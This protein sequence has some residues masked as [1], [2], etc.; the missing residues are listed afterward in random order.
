MDEEKQLKSA[1]DWQYKPRHTESLLGNEISSYLKKRHRTFVKNA[2]IIDTWETFI[3]FAMRPFCQLEKCVGNT[4][5]L[6]VQP[7]PYMHQAQMLSDELLEKINQRAP[8]CGIRKIKI[9]PMKKNN[10]E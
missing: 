10:T 7:G 8:R 6:Q 5:Y 3:P 1:L 9:V 2:S 4:L